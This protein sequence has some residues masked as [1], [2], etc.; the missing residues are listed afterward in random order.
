MIQRKWQTLF[1]YFFEC[2]LKMK[3]RIRFCSTFKINLT[4]KLSN[5]SYD[6]PSQ[7]PWMPA[8]NMP[9]GDQEDDQLQE[10]ENDHL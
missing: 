1:N 4:L 7:S 6:G 8:F 9:T 3:I 5:F 10:W 2:L